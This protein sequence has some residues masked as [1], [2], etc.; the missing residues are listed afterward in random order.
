MQEKNGL[1]YSDR[2]PKA[3]AERIKKINDGIFTA[4]EKKGTAKS[5]KE[6]K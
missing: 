5:A 1:L 3:A 4:D 2:T 6:R